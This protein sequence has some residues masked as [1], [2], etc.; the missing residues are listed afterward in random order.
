MGASRTFRGDR[1]VWSI[2]VIALGFAVGLAAVGLAAETKSPGRLPELIK[3]IGLDSTFEYIGPAIKASAKE[4]VAKSPNAAYRE[5]ALAGV[6][7][8]VNV[9]FAAETLQREFLAAMDGKLNKADLDAIFTFYK[10]PLGAR[11]TALENARN[12]ADASAQ[13]KEK[14]GELMEELKSKPERAEVLK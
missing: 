7:P 8:A 10:S 13:I 3:L 14:A 1:N 12:N 5:K 11:M 4:A 9:A 6:E 2:P